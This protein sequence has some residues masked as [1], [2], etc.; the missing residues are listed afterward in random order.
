[1][2]RGLKEIVK[3]HSEMGKLPGQFLV[4]KLAASNDIKEDKFTIELKAEEKAT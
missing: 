1:M 4:T 3:I 2:K